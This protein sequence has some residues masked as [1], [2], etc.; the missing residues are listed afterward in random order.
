VDLIT[1]TP[2]HLLW[3][4]NQTQP[5]TIYL[6]VSVS[7][8]GLLPVLATVVMTWIGH[9]RKWKT[10]WWWRWQSGNRKVS[11]KVG[12]LSCY[13]T[14]KA[15]QK[16]CLVWWI[17][18]R[19]LSQWDQLRLWERYWCIQKQEKEEITDYVYKIPCSNCEKTYIG[20]TGRKFGTR[21]KEHKTEVEAQQKT[22]HKKSA[23]TQFVRTKQVG[24]DWPCQSGQSHD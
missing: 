22:I 5:T 21:L 20:E 17:N 6:D 18:I 2:R 9:S 19:C 24:F 13:H 16:G 11:K 12:A 15:H 10:R 14:W 3:R 8:R 4:L 1:I 7:I 23:P